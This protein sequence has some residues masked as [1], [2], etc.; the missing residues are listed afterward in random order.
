[1]EQTLWKPHLEAG[2][3]SRMISTP[4]LNS[5][6]ALSITR[7]VTWGL[8]NNTC[9]SDYSNIHSRSC[10]GL[11]NERPLPT[12][13]HNEQLNIKGPHQMSHNAATE[14]LQPQNVNWRYEWQMQSLFQDSGTDNRIQQCFRCMNSYPNM[15]SNPC[16]HICVQDAAA[17]QKTKY[18]TPIM[19]AMWCVVLSHFFILFRFGEFGYEAAV[20]YKCLQGWPSTQ[21]NASN[22]TPSWAGWEAISPLPLFD[23][24]MC[25]HGSHS[26]H[27][28]LLRISWPLQNW[29]VVLQSL[30]SEYHF[31]VTC[32]HITILQ[33][34]WNT[35]ACLNLNI[36]TCICLSHDQ[37]VR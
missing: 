6:T 10:Q 1:M 28:C 36:N 34:L 37:C 12:T 31:R 18:S 20:L 30:P 17:S 13:Q 24:P 5:N 26:P 9:L 29:R 7:S 35:A 25:I 11:P 16:L 22:V 4:A 19:S 15:P 21:G 32:V 8:V 23:S 3:Y 14:P 2:I 27:H 33:W